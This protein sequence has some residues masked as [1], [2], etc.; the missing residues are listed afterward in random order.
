MK[1][2]I[3]IISYSLP[4]KTIGEFIVKSREI[5]LAKLNELIDLAEKGEISNLTFKY[6]VKE[7]K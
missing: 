1:W 7:V 3:F 2:Q 4:D 5:F 6:R